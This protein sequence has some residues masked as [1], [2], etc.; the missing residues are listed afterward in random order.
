MR[1]LQRRADEGREIRD[2][3]HAENSAAIAALT[4][5][6]DQHA[7]AVEDDAT[8]RRCAGT[9]AVEARRLGSDRLRRLRRVRVGRGGDGQM[10]GGMS[11][12]SH[13]H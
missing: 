13:W 12:L 10:G 7:A 6:L 8:R 11:L 3:R 9:I 5:K 1:E 4:R 2:R